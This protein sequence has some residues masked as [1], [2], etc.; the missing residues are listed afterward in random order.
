MVPNTLTFHLLHT[1]N[2]ELSL[3][4][5]IPLLV[6]ASVCKLCE[7]FLSKIKR[8]GELYIFTYN[9]NIIIN[10]SAEYLHILHTLEEN[11]SLG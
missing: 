3:K 9:N 7:I 6:H 11:L 5:T 8:K 10:I 2:L 4:N 1:F